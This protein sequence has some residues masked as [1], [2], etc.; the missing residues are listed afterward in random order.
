MNT[1]TACPAGSLR[2]VWRSG[3][4][5]ARVSAAFG[6]TVSAMIDVNPGIQFAAIAE[7]TAVCVPSRQLTCPDSDLYVIQSGDTLSAIAARYG[8]STLA[9]ME[10]NP[11]VEPTRLSIGQYICVPKKEPAQPPQE[12]QGA[13]GSDCPTAEEPSCEDFSDKAAK[14]CAASDTVQCGQSLYD[15]LVRYGITYQ[16]FA[17]LNPR[18]CRGPLVPGQKYWYPLRACAC[19]S[20]GKYIWKAGD[21]AS[22]VAAAVGISAS[23][24]MRRNPNLKPED[25]KEGTEICLTYSAK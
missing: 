11:Y 12:E 14:A 17:A 2:Y 25:L 15:I 4:T 19:P 22:S 18:L 10:M 16:E 21:T 1:P 13:T 5:L 23:E 20:S 9:L 6:T 24:I 3:D 8:I 7:G